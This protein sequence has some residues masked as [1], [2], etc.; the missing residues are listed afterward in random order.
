MPTP[1][2]ATQISLMMQAVERHQEDFRTKFLLPYTQA[3]FDMMRPSLY[4]SPPITDDMRQMLDD[5]GID[6]TGR[7]PFR[8]G[9]TIKIDIHG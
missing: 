5:M 9:D 1:T 6:W 3:L 4:P 2:T 8:S 7:L